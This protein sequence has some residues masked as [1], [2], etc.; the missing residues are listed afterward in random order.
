MIGNQAIERVGTD[1]TLRRIPGN[2]CNAGS[3]E[4]AV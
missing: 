3:A 4:S 2:A 1:W